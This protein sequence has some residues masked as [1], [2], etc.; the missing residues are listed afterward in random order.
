MHKNRPLL[1]SFK[2]S[3]VKNNKYLIPKEENN[4]KT[5]KVN[6][7]KMKSAQQKLPEKYRRFSQSISLAREDPIKL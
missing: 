3:P 1:N 7:N 4:K 2:D 6:T 5:Y